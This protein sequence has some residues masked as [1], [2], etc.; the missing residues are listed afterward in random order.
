[1]TAHTPPTYT[2]KRTRIHTE[3]PS[4]GVTKENCCCCCC[5]C[6]VVDRREGKTIGLVLLYGGWESRTNIQKCER[7]AGYLKK[8]CGVFH[9]LLGLSSEAERNPLTKRASSAPLDAQSTATELGRDRDM[10]RNIPMGALLVPQPK[11]RETPSAAGVQQA[12]KK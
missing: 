9:A 11:A 2:Q 4:V 12:R 7:G 5:C 3:A 1:M 8:T 10:R 6:V